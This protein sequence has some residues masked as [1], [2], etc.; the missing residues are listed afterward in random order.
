MTLS[1][2]R[3]IRDE[4]DEWR[5]CARVGRQCEVARTRREGANRRDHVGSRLDD[6]LTGRRL[7]GSVRL[8]LLEAEGIVRVEV[9]VLVVVVVVISRDG[10]ELV[11]RLSGVDLGRVRV[12]V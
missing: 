8:D 9:G 7:P 2:G 12:R 1:D 6:D 10:R 3:V 4:C 11:R 5:S